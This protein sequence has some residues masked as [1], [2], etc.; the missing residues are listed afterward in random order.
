MEK[1]K[2][3][4]LF[5]FKVLIGICRLSSLTQLQPARWLVQEGFDWEIIPPLQRPVLIGTGLVPDWI[6][7]GCCLVQKLHPVLELPFHAIFEVLEGQFPV[8]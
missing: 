4:F 5:D 7:S 3:R 2:I 8:L 6:C 1:S